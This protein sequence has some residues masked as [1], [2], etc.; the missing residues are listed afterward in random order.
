MTARVVAAAV[1][2]NNTRLDQTEAMPTSPMK[3]EFN[4]HK[5]SQ[6]SLHQEQ[7]SPGT[8]HGA[9]YEKMSLGCPDHI[10]GEGSNLVESKKYLR[11]LLYVL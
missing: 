5:Q 8:G 11:A 4:K 2:P 1:P 10:L 3:Q 9:N 6:V 7:A